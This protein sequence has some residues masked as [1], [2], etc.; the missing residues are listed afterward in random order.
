MHGRSRL[1]DWLTYRPMEGG[2][3]STTDWLSDWLPMWPSAYWNNSLVY[4]LGQECF[5]WTVHGGTV[6]LTQELLGRVPQ[7]VSVLWWR[8]SAPRNLQMSNPPLKKWSPRALP[9]TPWTWET[10]SLQPVPGLGQQDLYY[11]HNILLYICGEEHGFGPKLRNER[12]TLRGVLAILK[13]TSRGT[14][15]LPA[16]QSPADHTK[17]H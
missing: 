11:I 8:E 3:S 4:W 1:T 13:H 7:L 16:K 6:L 10:H 2:T 5:G 15:T 17:G 14:V 9:S 12:T